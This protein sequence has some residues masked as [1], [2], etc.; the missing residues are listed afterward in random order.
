[1]GILD[2]ILTAVESFA[3]EPPKPSGF[4]G[5]IKVKVTIEYENELVEFEAKDP[6]YIL[7]SDPYGNICKS[8]TMAA[9]E[10]MTKRTKS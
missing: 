10:K 8:I 3:P 7:D 4:Y 6:V 2:K 9:V 5:N 1:M